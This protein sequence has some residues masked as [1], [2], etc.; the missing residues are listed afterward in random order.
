GAFPAGG[1][2][3][4]LDGRLYGTTQGGGTNSSGAETTAGTIFSVALDG[5]GFTKH[6]SF[7]G[8]QG[9]SPNTRLLQLDDTTFAGVT[10][11]GG[12]CS[13]GT[14]YSFSLNGATVVGN[15]TCGQKKKNKSG[16]GATDPFVVLIGAALGLVSRRRRG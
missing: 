4:A 15:T 9:A 6:Y 11:S 16:G 3:L 2:T 10:P 13:Q 5:T 14:L 8:S 7:D 12:A 1:L